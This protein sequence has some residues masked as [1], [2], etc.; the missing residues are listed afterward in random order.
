MSLVGNL[1]DLGLGDIL[2]I[3]SLSRK[4]GVL[5]ISGDDNEGKIIFKNGQ[6][7][8]CTSTDVCEDL[9]EAIS[10]SALIS[11]EQLDEAIALHEDK[12]STETMDSI[13]T[14]HFG[15]SPD[16]IDA[17][18]KENIEKSAYSLF[19]WRTGTF[20]FE[21][22]DVDNIVDL[23]NDFFIYEHGIN[24]QFLA[25]EGTRLQDELHR[26]K[27]EKKGESKDAL[28]TPPEREDEPEQ[29]EEEK[30]IAE[31]VEEM[32]VPE[33][34]TLPVEEKQN[35]EAPQIPAEV[36]EA[37]VII[38]D[39]KSTLE[40][41]KNSLSSRHFNVFVE[42]KSENALHTISRLDNS[43]TNIVVVSDLIMPRMDGTGILGGIEIL[44]V[45]KGGFP[46]IPVVL[47][48]DHVNKE[49]ETRAHEMGVSLY[50]DK[51]KRSDFGDTAEEEKVN[52]FLQKLENA[53]RPLILGEESVSS[54]DISGMINLADGL[55]E[56]FEAVGTI[57]P[58]ESDELPLPSTPGLSTLKT[59][60]EE[61]NSPEGRKQISLLTL[62][63]A[64]ELMN[65]SVLFLVRSDNF[66][67]LGEFGV[68]IENDVADKRVRKMKLSKNAPS[69]L[70]DVLESG[71]S[72]RGKMEDTEGN[73]YIV[74]QLGGKFPKESYAGPII[75]EGKV[76]VIVYCDNVPEYKDI[77]DTS[78][79]EIFLMQAGVAM[80]RGLLE[81]KVR[82][83]SKN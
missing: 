33:K 63:F 76:S 53:L 16:D 52:L 35:K 34:A 29:V 8:R 65:R 42:E 22:K 55:E 81:R 78:A 70:K 10:S 51:P 14:T 69:I 48:S 43:G 45:L 40:K 21:L 32:P 25:M 61:L 56:E 64:S 73:R 57:L 77:D 60:V 18:K 13:L 41:I 1:E 58:Q 26:D 23:R 47:M 62:R 59:M 68:E 28:Q 9:K 3:V 11:S 66:E 38:D 27:D 30:S 31:K 83:I 74:D 24:P 4:S 17:L 72:I 44:E 12:S 36:H 67:G 80:E 19:S 54:E 49:A 71:V 15:V 39:D 2:Q 6:V 7:I 75:T 82:E 37:I 5:F 20:N 46:N 79:F 50:I